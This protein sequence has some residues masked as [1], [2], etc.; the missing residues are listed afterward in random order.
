MMGSEGNRLTTLGGQGV[1]GFEWWGFGS[2][3]HAAGSCRLSPL[4]IAHYYDVCLAHLPFASADCTC[5][6]MRFPSRPR[7]V[8]PL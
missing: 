8:M 6:A 3:R 1:A 4:C 7:S 2:V 5:R